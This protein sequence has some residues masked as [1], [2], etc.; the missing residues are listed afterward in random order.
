VGDAMVH[1]QV[2][3]MVGINHRWTK[4]A[5][6]TLYWLDDIEQIEAI[7]SIVGQTQKV[8]AFYAKYSCSRMSCFFAPSLGFPCFATGTDS[9]GKKQHTDNITRVGMAGNGATAAQDFVVRMR[10]NYK[11]VFGGH[12][13][14]SLQRMETRAET[15][16]S[17]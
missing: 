17:F 15:L 11:D 8:H 9:I 3:A 5:H 1:V 10:R 2:T 16:P 6:N 14:S 7:K 12:Y 4:L 13:L